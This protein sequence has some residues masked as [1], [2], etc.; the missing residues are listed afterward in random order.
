MQQD[1]KETFISRETLIEGYLLKAYRDKVRVS[2][3]SESIREWI[4]HMGA[5]V[6]VPLFEDGTTLLLHQFR[7]PAQRVFIEL[8]AGKLDVVGEPPIAAA[9]RE[10]EEETGYTADELIPLGTTFPCI[11]YSNEEI[12]IFLA[13]KLRKIAV[14]KVVGEV[15]L[16]FQI[17]FEEALRMA[18]TGE[19]LDAKTALALIRANAFLES[20][21]T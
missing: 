14:E 10:L 2:D 20:E 9:Q 6:V 15:V 12:H 21:R 1:L 7:Y 18:I 4:N 19:I 13:R 16:P 11:G 17:A 8:P 3:G 5:A